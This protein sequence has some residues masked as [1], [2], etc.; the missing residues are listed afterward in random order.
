[1]PGQVA[2]VADPPPELGALPGGV[3]AEDP[4]LTGGWAGGG[5]HQDHAADASRDR[6]RLRKASKASPARPAAATAQGNQA[7]GPAGWSSERMAEPYACRYE[8]TIESC[9]SPAAN[10]RAMSA[11]MSMQI[12]ISQTSRRV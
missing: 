3:E 11:F 1:M 2:E 7:A 4:Q 12:G 5:R 10:R 6:A 9:D 8:L